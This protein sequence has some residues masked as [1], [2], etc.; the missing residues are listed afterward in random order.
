[1]SCCSDVM[2]PIEAASCC[3]PQDTAL[4]AAKAMRDTGCG[5]APVVEDKQDLKLVGV[6]TAHDISHQVAAE[7]RRASEIAVKDIMKP[8]SACCASDEPLEEARRKLHEHQ[9]TSLPVLDSEGSCCGT[10]SVHH[11]Q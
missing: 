7:D 11:L 9:A 4:D 2:K 5:C 6:V 10:V 8:A 1:M 3:T